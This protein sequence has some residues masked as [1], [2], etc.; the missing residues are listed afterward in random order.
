MTNAV[1]IYGGNS[2]RSRLIGI[3]DKV[4]SFFNQEGIISETIFVH[5]LPADD[6]ISA[7]FNS[8][9]ILKA[10]EKVA[11]A[12]IIIIL[13]PVYKAAYTGILK[14]YL[15]LLPQKELVGK[16]ILPLVLGGSFGHLLV[17][18]YALK[19]V[20][21][22]LGATNIISGAYVLDTEIEKTKEQQY[23][24]APE[25]SKRL[26]RVLLLS[27]EEADRYCASI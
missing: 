22:A 2:K 6:L 26:E 20:L 15:D 23:K 24:L 19:P 27:K 9:P 5:E 17:I 8:E 3:W 12:D 14:T 13:T 11:N 1:I 4:E 21:S 18:D 25:I 7:N 16:T 10:N